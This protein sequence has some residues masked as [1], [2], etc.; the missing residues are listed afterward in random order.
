MVDEAA[1]AVEFD[2]GVAVGDFE[3]K[4]LRAAFERGGFGEVEKLRGDAFTAVSGQDEEFVDPCALAAIFQAEIKTDGEVGDGDLPVP[5]KKNQ[6]VDRIMQKLLEVMANDEL[7]EGFIP[8]VVQ[9]HLEHEVKQRADI[10]G[11]CA[12]KREGRGHK[13]R[14]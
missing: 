4:S 12:V 14:S 1:A 3:M 5:G 10:G 11:S 7:V 6:A 9:L 2:G 8:R 13:F